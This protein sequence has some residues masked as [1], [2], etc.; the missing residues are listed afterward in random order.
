MPMFGVVC[1]KSRFLKQLVNS[2]FGCCLVLRTRPTGTRNK[3]SRPPTDSFRRHERNG[4]LRILKRDSVKN[5]V[6]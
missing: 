2:Q 4:G 6:S 1:S 3:K 5:H